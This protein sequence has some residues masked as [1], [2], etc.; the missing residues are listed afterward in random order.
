MERRA[1]PSLHGSIEQADGIWQSTPALPTI[2]EFLTSV[3]VDQNGILVC[4][5]ST[6]KG[7]HSALRGLPWT[8]R[9][10]VR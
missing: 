2:R 9:A 4:S 8:P 1:R 6:S 10:P 3:A 5:K 7:Y